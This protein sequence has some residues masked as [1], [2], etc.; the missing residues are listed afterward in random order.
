MLA[1]LVAAAAAA[2]LPWPARPVHVIVAQGTGGPPDRIARFV[3]EPL[4]RALG[5]PVVIENR[6]GASGI[7]GVTAAARAA[8]DG[9]TM[10]IGT[11]STHALV[12]H[13]NRSVAYDPLRDF[14]PVIN[15]FRSVK[16]LWIHPA[17]PVSTLAEWLAYVRARPGALNY[18]S[19]GV[20]SSNHVD[21]AVLCAAT[22]LDLLHVPYG[23]PAAAIAA[24]AKGDA[25]A[26]VVSIGTGLPLAQGKRI[27]PLVVF[28]QRRSPLLPQVPTASEEGLGRLDLGAWIGLFA[29]AGTPDA[30]VLRANAVLAQILR[31]P[32]TIAWAEREGLEILGGAP[33]AFGD[34]V[35]ADY[36]RWGDVI[37]RLD[38]QPE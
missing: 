19:G 1:C 24:V 37:R 18:S 6:P 2:D 9:Y 31:A 3:A 14:V 8:P 20:G 21:M 5:V 34:T 38:L 7:I 30:I 15:L 36:R 16:V 27:R 32:D 35:A 33:A 28:A 22:D 23:G 10:L 4:S 12:P 11:L 26:M 17:L 25:Q 13:A 29:P